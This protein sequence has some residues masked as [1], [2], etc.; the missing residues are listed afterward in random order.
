M[1]FNI[2]IAFV[3]CI[4]FATF[5]SLKGEMIFN[6]LIVKAI[7]MIKIKL[8][9]SQKKKQKFALIWIFPITVMFVSFVI[10]YFANVSTQNNVIITLLSG[11][12]GSLLSIHYNIECLRDLYENVSGNVRDIEALQKIKNNIENIDHPYFQKWTRT[13]LEMILEHNRSLFS[14]KNYTNPHAEDTFGIEG[15]RYTRNN[16]TLKATS[17]VPDYW[18]DDFTKQYLKVQEELIRDKKVKIQRIF[19]FPKAMKKKYIKLM[20]DQVNIGI[21][22]RYIHKEN[23]FIYEDWLNEDYLI[24]DDK[25]LV[26]IFCSTHKCDKGQNEVGNE[27]ITIDPIIVREKIERF[28]RLLERSYK[29]E[30]RN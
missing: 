7:E 28:E 16:G 27:L 29:F 5:E 26:Q 6:N 4:T 2:A 15:L 11:C 19:I 20:K 8:F 30:K 9:T 10:A 12:F 1:F 23:K 13:K 22:V 14:G 3:I 24:Q 18:L 17:V 21:D 25:L